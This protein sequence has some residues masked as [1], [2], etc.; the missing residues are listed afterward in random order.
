MG[1]DPGCPFLAAGSHLPP[2]RPLGAPG[3][4]CGAAGAGAGWPGD[5]GCRAALRFR[6]AERSL[7]YRRVETKSMGDGRRPGSAPHP[8]QGVCVARRA[9]TGTSRGPTAPGPRAGIPSP[10]RS[11]TPI[12][13]GAGRDPRPHGDGIWGALT[14]ALP[15][16]TSRNPGCHVPFTWAHPPASLSS[17]HPASHPPLP[18][19]SSGVASCPSPQRQGRQCSSAGMAS[20]PSQPHCPYRCPGLQGGTEGPA[21]ARCS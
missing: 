10:G 19:C 7:F 20:Q 4:A 12:S 21:T 2:A 17:Q 1:S 5:S 16:G 15:L 3:P 18:P 8:R 11:R 14:P 13:P 6:A 9:G